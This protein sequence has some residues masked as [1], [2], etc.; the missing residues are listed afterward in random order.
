MKKTTINLILIIVSSALS[1][2]V[3]S[4]GY[5]YNNNFDVENINPYYES[6]YTPVSY[7]PNNQGYYPQQAQTHLII[8]PRHII[9]NPYPVYACSPAFP[10]PRHIIVNPFPVYPIARRGH[11]VRHIRRGQYY[12][13]GCR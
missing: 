9:V 8:N 5:G 10:Y 2:N 4:Q 13:R 6:N 12:S 11:I 1:V 3:Y 7:Y